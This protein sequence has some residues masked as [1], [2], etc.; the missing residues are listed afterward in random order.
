[1]V[2]IIRLTELYILD[3][4]RTINTTVKGFL[5]LPTKFVLMVILLM[6]LKV[7][8]EFKLTSMVINTTDYGKMIKKT[9]KVF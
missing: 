2:L 7:V 5:N 1:M 9:E 8:K 4:S 3:L 6:D